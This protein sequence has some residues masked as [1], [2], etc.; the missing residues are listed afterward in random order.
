MTTRESNKLLAEFL[1]YTQPHPDYPHTTYWYKKDEAPLTMLSFDT[2]WNWL[3]EVVE[4]I[5]SLGSSEVMDR[6][7]YSRFEIYGN[8][9]QLDWRRDNQ[10]LLRLEVCQKQMLTHKG[11]S[12]KEYKKNDIEKNTT[13]M[14]ALYIACVEFVKWYNKNK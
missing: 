1:G 11:Y 6:K 7:I 14:E 2:D 9:I 4:K 13:R 5:E 3:M 12:W 8:H 10:D